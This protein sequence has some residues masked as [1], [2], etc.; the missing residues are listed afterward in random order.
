MKKI[1]LAVCLLTLSISFI[2][3]QSRRPTT[4][5]G[6]KKNQRPAATPTPQ[7]TDANAEIVEGVI[8]VNT[9]I[10]T[11]PVKVLDRKSKFVAGLTK[12]D[13]KVFEENVE[14]EITYFSNE[15]E[16]FTVALVLD[17]SYSAKFKEAEIQSAAIAF[18]NELSPKDRV[19]IVAFTGEVRVLC[20]PTNDKKRLFAAIKS[21]KI[22][23]GTS[24]YDAVDLVLNDKLAKIGGRKAIVLFS[25]GVDTS[26]ERASDMSNKSTAIESDSLIYVVQYDTFAEVQA[27][28]NKPIVPQTTQIPGKDKSPFPIPN[29]GMMSDKGTSREEYEKADLYL[30]ELA[31]R[32]GGEVFKA[33]DIVSISKSFSKVAAELREFYS[34]G[35]APKE[36]S[37]DGKRHKIKVKVNRENVAVKARD[38]YTAKPV[39]P[40]KK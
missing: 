8:E 22:D 25:D 10:V 39:T 16:P 31:T 5:D 20:E 35:F 7:T 1:A 15:Q 40:S 33:N 34:I 17:M 3:A 6:S 12:E 23:F 9:E 30:S 14:Q 4:D 29:V 21:T 11:I 18:L 2:F 27:M 38:S 32:T 19:M 24:V 28:K 13:F 36:E 26:S 37:K